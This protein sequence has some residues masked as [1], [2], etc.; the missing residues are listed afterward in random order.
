[1]L[2]R[3]VDRMVFSVVEPPVYREARFSITSA[4]SAIFPE[5]RVRSV[6][7]FLLE[8]PDA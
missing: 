6:R 3:A 2:F 1:M 8:K 4:F 5:S 7:P